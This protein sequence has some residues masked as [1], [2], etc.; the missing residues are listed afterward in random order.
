[1]TTNDQPIGF[2]AGKDEREFI[3]DLVKWTGLKQSQVIRLALR[4]LHQE[5][6]K[7][8]AAHVPGATNTRKR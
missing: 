4:R 1:M 6:S 5:E 7:R 3:V 2:R 8:Q